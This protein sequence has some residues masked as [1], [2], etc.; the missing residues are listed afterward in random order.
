MSEEKETLKIKRT[1]DYSIFKKVTFNRDITE[2]HVKRMK[3]L[4]EKEN[5]L[6]GHPILVNKDMELID[7]QHRFLAAKELGLEVFYI[8]DDDLSYDHIINSNYG[9]KKMELIDFFKFYAE[10]DKNPNYIE[11]LK[12][13][14]KLSIKSRPLLSLLFGFL[15]GQLPKKIKEGTFVY[16]FEAQEKI[17]WLTGVYQRFCDFMKE[18]K[19]ES[20]LFLRNGPFCGAFRTLLLLDGF[21]EEFFFSQ[22]NKAWR[23]I[24]PQPNGAFWFQHLL[25]FYNQQ[26]SYPLKSNDI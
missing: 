8:Q 24:E 20:Y 17:E 6:N 12:L 3:K 18:R 14:K 7:G 23:D 25:D 19:Y 22:L 1:K 4:L 16:P 13:K 15:G 21:D 9:Q 11:F 26:N 2:A 10:K 5:L